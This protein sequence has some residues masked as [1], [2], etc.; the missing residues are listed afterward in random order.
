M[1]DESEKHTTQIS[2][3]GFHPLVV[4][5]MSFLLMP[6]ER[7]VSLILPRKRGSGQPPLRLVNMSPRT[8]LNLLAWLEQE[9]DTLTHLLEEEKP[10]ND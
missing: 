9:R 10:S 6:R 1:I 2:D 3:D 8:A 4:E 7:A 5:H